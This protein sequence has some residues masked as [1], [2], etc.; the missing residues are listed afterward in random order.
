MPNDNERIANSGD[1]QDDRQGV[2]ERVASGVIADLI[3]DREGRGRQHEMRQDFYTSFSKHEVGDDN[4]NETYDGNEV[5]DSLHQV[6]P[7]VRPHSIL[8]V[9]LSHRAPK[10]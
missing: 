7:I 3:S 4:A 2:H 1:D 8:G 5:I 9:R 10:T 6:G